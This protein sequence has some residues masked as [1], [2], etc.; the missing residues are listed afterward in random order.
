MMEFTDIFLIFCTHLL[1]SICYR[2]I[3]IEHF[4]K[5]SNKS[6]KTRKSN[7]QQQRRS[8]NFNRTSH[9]TRRGQEEI[10]IRV[11]NPINQEVR[12]IFGEEF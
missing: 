2:Y 12:P 8:R 6:S 3:F 11:R 5:K 10:R 1:A 4:V 7:G 9:R